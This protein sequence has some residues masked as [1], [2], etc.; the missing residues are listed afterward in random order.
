MEP[1]NPTIPEWWRT[2]YVEGVIHVFQDKGSRLM[3]T[4]RRRN[5]NDSE[6]LQFNLFGTLITTKKGPGD[7]IP[8][9]NPV[10]LKKVVTP[11][12]DF[13][14]VTIEKTDVEKMPEDERDECNKAG[15]RALA[16]RADDIIIEAAALTTTPSLTGAGTGIFMSPDL[17]E[18]INEH[19]ATN[20]ID[21]DEEIFNIVSARAFRHLMRF[22]EFASSDYVGPDLPWGRTTRRGARTWNGQHWIR[23]NRLP[24]AGN[25][26]TCFSWTPSAIAHAT[27]AD[28]FVH[29]SWENKFNHWFGNMHMTQGAAI[30]Q[31]IGVVPVKIDESIDPITID[32]SPG[33]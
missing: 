30:L 32:P 27:L 23:F 21:E 14:G 2:E 13:V 4:T 5:A 17:S 31:D 20:E 7:A 18:Q 10:H 6:E 8:S 12:T 29:F 28:L 15:G 1:F 16:R 25:I 3:K 33:G 24:K 26:R 19:F 22:P 11:D 9:Q